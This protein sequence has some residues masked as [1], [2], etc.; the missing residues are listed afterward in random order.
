MNLRCGTSSALGDLPT[1]TKPHSPDCTLLSGLAPYEDSG[2]GVFYS[3]ITF[4]TL[5]PK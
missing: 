3:P 4:L 1:K 5:D 2:I